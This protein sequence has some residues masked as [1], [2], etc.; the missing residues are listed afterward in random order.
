MPRDIFDL[1]RPWEL[2]ELVDRVAREVEAHRSLDRLS[3]R[4]PRKARHER[5]DEYVIELEGRAH[6][7]SM[8]YGLADPCGGGA[9]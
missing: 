9:L 1:N 7:P 6:G 3:L 4:Y 8:P 2:P 5:G